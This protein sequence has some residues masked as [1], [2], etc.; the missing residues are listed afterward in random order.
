MKNLEEKITNMINKIGIDKVLHALIF[1]WITQVGL[2]YSFT[3]GVWAFLILFILSIIK[4]AI[5]DKKGDSLDVLAG[6]VGG[7]IAFITYIPKDILS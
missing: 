6:V 4:E 2:T 7:M 5:I 3:T 1:G